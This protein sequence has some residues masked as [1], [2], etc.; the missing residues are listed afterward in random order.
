LIDIRHEVQH[1]PTLKVDDTKQ[2]GR[3]QQKVVANTTTV[4]AIAGV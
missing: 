3:L 1:Q 2:P 4:T